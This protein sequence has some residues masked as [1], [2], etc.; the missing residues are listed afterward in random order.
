MNG[1]ACGAVLCFALSACSSDPG[2]VSFPTSAGAAGASAAPTAGAAGA[3][4]AS[5]PYDPVAILAVEPSPGC[6]LA[7]AQALGQFVRYTIQTSGTKDATASDTK[8]G[9]WSYEREYAVWLPP[10]YDPTHAY[11]LV[12]QAPGCGGTSVN[13][14]SLSPSNMGGDNGV[15]GTVIRV[16][17]TPPPDEIGHPTVP[18]GRCFDDHEGDDSVEWPFYEAV[19]D[20]LKQ[21]LCYDENRVFVSGTGSGGVLAEELA[22]K[23]AGNP[24][25]YAIRGLATVRGTLPDDPKY[26]PTC[27]SYPIAGVWLV[28]PE[29]SYYSA[30]GRALVAN[31]CEAD[32][33]DRATFEDYPLGG[34]LPSGTCRKISGCPSELPLVT[35]SIVAQAMSGHDDVANPAFAKLIESLEAPGSA[36]GSDGL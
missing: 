2:G 3:S 27:T 4:N 7:P 21:Q 32:I 9:D 28:A 33:L 36:E 31:H 22:C 6:G 13:V 20:R 25:G 29:D 17:L 26:R 11:P 5:V 15:K 19:V 18:N 1:K 24:R 34:S 16:G 30:I 8:K 10:L 23:Y 14:N 35:C 12:F